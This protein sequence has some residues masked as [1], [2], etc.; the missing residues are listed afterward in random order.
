MYYYTISIDEQ[1]LKDTI[2]DLTARINE[3]FDKGL[4]PVR[5]FQILTTEESMDAPTMGGRFVRFHLVVVPG[6]VA[7]NEK[8][9]WKFCD[10]MRTAA[11]EV[12]KM[13]NENYVVV[14]PPRHMP[15]GPR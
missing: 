2:D 9:A 6:F 1:G 11:L 5:P 13:N 14:Q 15:G 8:Q 10:M 7:K 12:K 4:K 3:P